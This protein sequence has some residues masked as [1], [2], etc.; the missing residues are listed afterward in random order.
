DADVVAERAAAHLE[1]RRL[2]LIE[3]FLL[4]DRRAVAH[5]EAGPLDEI[6]RRRRHA[7]RRVAAAGQPPR[8]RDLQFAILFVVADDK[9]PRGDVVEE[10]EVVRQT[11][12]LEDHLLHRLFVGLA[13]DLP[14]YGS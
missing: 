11:E 12:R 14:L 9:A 10:E 3:G 13:G 2:H 8:T 7:A 4:Q 6:A 1:S 5:V